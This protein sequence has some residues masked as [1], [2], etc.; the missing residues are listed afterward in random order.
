MK[1]EEKVKEQIDWEKE[2]EKYR[3]KRAGEKMKRENLMD[4]MNKIQKR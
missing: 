4:K 2:E 3:I 1:E